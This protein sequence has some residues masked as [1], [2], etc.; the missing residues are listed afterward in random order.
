MYRAETNQSHPRYV[1]K[2]I[3]MPH[4]SVPTNLIKD[5]KIGT[6]SSSKPV[7]ENRRPNTPITIGRK[8]Q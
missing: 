4:Q 6:A 3:A 1:K 5:P 2:S 7:Y 8:I